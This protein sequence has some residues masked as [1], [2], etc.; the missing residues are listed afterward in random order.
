MSQRMLVVSRSSPN[1]EN[2]FNNFI[3]GLK[4]ENKEA[5]ETVQQLRTLLSHGS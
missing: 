5:G 4:T 1:P 2:H 3:L